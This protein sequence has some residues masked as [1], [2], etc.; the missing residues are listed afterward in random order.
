VSNLMLWAF[1][2]STRKGSDF[3]RGMVLDRETSRWDSL[4]RKSGY[5]LGSTGRAGLDAMTA[6]WRRNSVRRDA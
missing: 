6:R 2:R 4:S 3:V 1:S 5:L